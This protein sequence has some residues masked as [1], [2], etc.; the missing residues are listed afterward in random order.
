MEEGTHSEIDLPLILHLFY[1]HIHLIFL[2]RSKL[3]AVRALGLNPFFSFLPFKHS[4]EHSVV[5]S[6]Y[7]LIDKWKTL[8]IVVDFYREWEA[9]VHRDWWKW[10]WLVAWEKTE[11]WGSVTPTMGWWIPP[12]TGKFAGRTIH[13]Q[14]VEINILVMRANWRLVKLLMELYSKGS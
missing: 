12:P 13:S 3:L 10:I 1:K 9:H 6:K 14:G 5:L 8:T 4:F 11:R 2:A 7:L